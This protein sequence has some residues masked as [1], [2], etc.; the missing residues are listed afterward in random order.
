MNRFDCVLW[1]W[2]FVFKLFWGDEKAVE[3]FLRVVRRFW[4]GFSLT[5]FLVGVGQSVTVWNV[6][7]F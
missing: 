7:V 4:A 1:V 2:G 5:Q 6:F 3:G